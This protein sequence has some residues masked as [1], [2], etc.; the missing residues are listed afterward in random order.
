MH[1]CAPLTAPL[2]ENRV[3]ISKNSFD[4]FNGTYQNFSI[5]STN[6]RIP[7]LWMVL[8]IENYSNPVGTKQSLN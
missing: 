1:S 6:R 8:G 3:E 5:D 2:I 4:M 7:S